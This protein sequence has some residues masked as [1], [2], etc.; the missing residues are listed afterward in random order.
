MPHNL[1]GFVVEVPH[2]VDFAKM[3]GEIGQHYRDDNEFGEAKRKSANHTRT[4]GRSVI[5]DFSPEAEVF[6][7]VLGVLS[8]GNG[9]SQGCMH[10]GSAFVTAEISPRTGNGG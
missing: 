9:N 1:P 6:V 3:A 5:S 7:D 10:V 8:A 2:V 4:L